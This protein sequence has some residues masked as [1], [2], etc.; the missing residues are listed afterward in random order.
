MIRYFARDIWIRY[1]TQLHSRERVF[2]VLPENDSFIRTLRRALSVVEKM[3]STTTASKNTTTTTTTSTSIFK[4]VRDTLLGPK[5]EEIKYLDRMYW[6]SDAVVSYVSPVSV[7]VVWLQRKLLR[8]DLIS[9]IAKDSPFSVWQPLPLYGPF[10]VKSIPPVPRKPIVTVRVA[11][12]SCGMMGTIVMLSSY[13]LYMPFSSQHGLIMMLVIFPLITSFLTYTL[14]RLRLLRVSKV[15]KHYKKNENQKLKVGEKMRHFGASISGLSPD[16]KYLVQIHDKKQ[17]TDLEFM[18]LS[19]PTPCV[20]S[21]E[22]C[23]VAIVSDD[24]VSSN[25]EVGKMSPIVLILKRWS[26]SRRIDNKIDMKLSDVLELETTPQCEFEIQTRKRGSWNWSACHILAICSENEK[27]GISKVNGVEW[28]VPYE[29]IRFGVNRSH[30]VQEYR[31][32][33]RLVQSYKVTLSPWSEVLRVDDNDDEKEEDDDE[34]KEDKDKIITIENIMVE[35]LCPTSAMITWSLSSSSYRPKEKSMMMK[36]HVQCSIVKKTSG[37][38]SLLSDSSMWQNFNV[39]CKTNRLSV[40]GLKGGLSYHIRIRHDASSWCDVIRFTTPR[41]TQTTKTQEKNARIN[42]LDRQANEWDVSR[43]KF[44]NI[45]VVS[46]TRTSARVAWS[47]NH[48]AE[49]EVQYAKDFMVSKW[50][51]LTDLVK[52]VN[53][54]SRPRCVS[55]SPAIGHVLLKKLDPCQRYMVRIRVKYQREYGEYSS[56]LYFTTTSVASSSS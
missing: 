17:K 24:N 52:T 38:M 3:S 50:I 56:P 14:L 1:Y 2:I 5:E 40:L 35:T 54:T 20:F 9:K 10:S 18:T 11:Q 16:A 19:V 27:S 7:R 29:T 45:R 26:W 44:S 22:L 34:K 21:R 4:Y 41:M 23:S 48:D 25:D 15:E 13:Y 31:V 49:F 6:R 55:Y 47:S 30:L 37:K 28:I 46:V 12:I 39:K 53:D 32:R 51:T 8:Q 42:I 33:A 43:I 36:Y